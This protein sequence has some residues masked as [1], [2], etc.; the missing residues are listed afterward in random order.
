MS[1]SVT[2][3]A[4]IKLFQ[5]TRPVNMIPANRGPVQLAYYYRVSNCFAYHVKLPN[6]ELNIL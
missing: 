4:L 5:Q 1:W 3:S 2:F 6:K